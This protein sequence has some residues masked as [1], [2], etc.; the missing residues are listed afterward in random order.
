MGLRSLYF[1]LA[2][3]MAKFKYLKIALAFLLVG[4]G[5]KMIFHSVYQMGHAL[6]LI[7]IAAIIGIGVVASVLFGPEDEAAKAPE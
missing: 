3:A 6:S 5:A 2:G 4:I 7:I 1:V